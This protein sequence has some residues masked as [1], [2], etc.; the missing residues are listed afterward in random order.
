MDEQFTD[1]DLARWYDALCAGRRDFDFYLPLV[2]A[3]PAVLDVGCGT[4][5]L[6]HLARA[7]GHPGRL[8]GLDPAAE[9][10]AVARERPDI[11]VE[12]VH[13]DLTTSTWD[14]EFD[15]VVMTGHAFQELVTDDQVRTALAGIHRA[16]RPR[17]RF[18]F[19]TRNPGARAWESWT[20]DR[21]RE[22]TRGST[23]L[24]VGHDATADGDLVRFTTTYTADTGDRRTSAST[25]RFLD[26]PALVE[27]LTAAGFAVERQFGDWDR[28]PLTAGSPEIITIART[29]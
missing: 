20:P 18:A 6:L 26:H 8:C 1:P 13:G 14:A 7:A 2:L 28:S 10:L 21:S 3:A 11:E 16:L 17:G 24:R 4:G 22:V 9:M 25:L 5:E 27:S 15:L 12:W 19:E 23:T 29:G